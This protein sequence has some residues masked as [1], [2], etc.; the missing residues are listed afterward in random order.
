M[1][2][3]YGISGPSLLIESTD[4]MI[5]IISNNKTDSCRCVVFLVKHENIDFISIVGFAFLEFYQPQDASRWMEQHKVCYLFLVTI[6]GLCV[7][8]V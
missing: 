5:I 6:L 4:S 2:Y 3:I 7:F 8:I 1:Y